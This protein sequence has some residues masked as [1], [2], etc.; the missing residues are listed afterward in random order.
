M[1]QKGKRKGLES[2]VRNN[3]LLVD[4]LDGSINGFRTKSDAI[5]WVYTHC[6]G[7]FYNFHVITIDAKKGLV[8]KNL[9]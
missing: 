9:R 2:G 7:T 8:R 3:W 5:H 6:A 4:K 1:L